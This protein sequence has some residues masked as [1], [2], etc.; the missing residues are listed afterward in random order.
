MYGI[1]RAMGEK[2]DSYCDKLEM[3]YRGLCESGSIYKAMGEKEYVERCEKMF[4]CSQR[5][6]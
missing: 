1:Y 5:L 3:G 6:V 4:G 2:W